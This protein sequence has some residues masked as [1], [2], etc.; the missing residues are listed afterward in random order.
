LEALNVFDVVNETL[1]R[2]PGGWTILFP[3]VAIPS[4]KPCRELVLFEDLSVSIST[5]LRDDLPLRRCLLQDAV[6][7]EEALR[8]SGYVVGICFYDLIAEYGNACVL[9]WAGGV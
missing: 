8:E 7:D 9:R 1:M 2:P 6:P 4:P 3:S 5:F